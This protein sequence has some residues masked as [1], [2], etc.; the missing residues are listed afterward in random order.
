MSR[1][2]Q[3]GRISSSSNTQPKSSSKKSGKNSQ[4]DNSNSKTKKTKKKQATKSQRS[5]S[6]QAQQREKVAVAAAMSSSSSSSDDDEMVVEVNDMSIGD[7]KDELKK[8]HGWSAVSLAKRKTKA[9][10]KSLLTNCRS[11]AHNHEEDDE[12]DEDDSEGDEGDSDSDYDYDGKKSKKRKKKSKQQPKSNVPSKKKK[13]NQVT[14]NGD[15][16]VVVVVDIL[17]STKTHVTVKKTKAPSQIVISD[18]AEWKPNPLNDT[19]T[20]AQVSEYIAYAQKNWYFEPEPV[21]RDDE[22]DVGKIMRCVLNQDLIQLYVEDTNSKGMNNMCAADGATW[23]AAL[24]AAKERMTD[25]GQQKMILHVCVIMVLPQKYIRRRYQAPRASSSSNGLGRG[26]SGS[27][28]SNKKKPPTKKVD[29]WKVILRVVLQEGTVRLEKEDEEETYVAKLEG[30][31]NPMFSKQYDITECFVDSNNEDEREHHDLHGSLAQDPSTNVVGIASAI[32]HEP[33]Q[34]IWYDEALPDLMETA[35]QSDKIKAG[36]LSRMYAV[37]GGKNLRGLKNIPKDLISTMSIRL[38]DWKTNAAKKKWKSIVVEANDDDG[39]G[40]YIT[41]FYLQPHMFTLTV[42][43]GQ[44]GGGFDEPF[45]SV[46]HPQTNTPSK[47]EVP[48]SRVGHNLA[49]TSRTSA[50]K[51]RRSEM[52]NAMHPWFLRDK[53]QDGTD[54]PWFKA[55]NTGH[56]AHIANSLAKSSTASNKFVDT[57]E[58]PSNTWTASVNESCGGPPAR[59]RYP[60]ME[61]PPPPPNQLPQKSATTSGGDDSNADM[62]RMYKEIQANEIR[63][64]LLQKLKQGT[65]QQYQFST[66]NNMYSHQPSVPQQQQIPA[67]SQDTISDVSQ[68]LLAAHGLPAA[69]EHK[70][71]LSTAY[72]IL[73]GVDAAQIGK[74]CRSVSNVIRV[75]RSTSSS[76]SSSYAVDS[77]L[78]VLGDE[79]GL[80]KVCGA[81]ELLLPGLN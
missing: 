42:G 17:D 12:E 38:Q 61:Q 56:M 74:L 50:A 23:D 75:H 7:I 36:S 26:R 22:T 6:R 32:F 31:G 44:S 80:L 55:F 63:S 40:G 29:N 25:E 24:D 43:V 65:Q 5:S 52:N 27:A 13:K 1:K 35:K 8:V 39:E 69:V 67:T 34:R 62:L 15:V 4:N 21:V 71:D 16:E 76:S 3:T 47:K 11:I 2:V 72:N 59:G 70:K 64:M 37:E 54:N 77:I 60:T 51:S 79:G 28:S 57:G 9:E 20:Q 30:S 73:N 45:P 33:L 10:W 49:T 19:C 58:L 53:N 81:L 46:N 41:E 66:P 68:I 14:R 48:L 18:Y 78:Q